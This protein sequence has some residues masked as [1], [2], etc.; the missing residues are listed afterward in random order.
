MAKCKVFFLALEAAEPLLLT[1]WM[2][3]GLLPQLAALRRRSLH[4]EARCLRGIGANAIWPSVYTG[5]GPATHGRYYH[6]QL[7]SGGY[8]SISDCET[9][10]EH[11]TIWDAASKAGLQVGMVD[12]PRAFTSEHFHGLQIIDWNTHLSHDGFESRPHGIHQHVEARFGRSKPCV[13]KTRQ[14][15]EPDP[16][17]AKGAV[18]EIRESIARSLSLTRDQLLSRDWDL[19][20]TA[21]DQLH[22]A[23]HLLWHRHDPTHPWHAYGSEQGYDPL[24]DLYQEVDTAVGTLLSDLPQDCTTVIF[25]GPGMGPSYVRPELLDSILVALEGGRASPARKLVTGLKALWHYL[26]QNSRRHLS[27]LA[28]RADKGLQGLDRS[29]RR[30]F[31]VKSNDAV[32]GIRVNLR[33]REANGL[34]PVEEMDGFCSSLIKAIRAIRIVDTGEPLVADIF[35]VTD[36]YQGESIDQLPDILIEWNQKSAISALTS[37]DTGVIRQDRLPDWSGTHTS[38]SLVMIQ[39]PGHGEGNLPADAGILDIAPTLAE[40][41]GLPTLN[42]EGKSLLAGMAGGRVSS[43]PISWPRI[44]GS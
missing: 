12:L 30:C 31:S 33:G 42:S 27:S 20:L 43:S 7:Q 11:Q 25:T 39:L 8:Q 14:Y 41:C 5:V 13:C 1:R 35:R 22:C 28:K 26:P 3:A 15:F 23:G 24:L 32:G 44:L 9:R 2:D 40:L 29:G 34:V 6:D 21:L 16:S 37:S 4:G 10:V 38:R 17:E 36:L 19:Y 18:T